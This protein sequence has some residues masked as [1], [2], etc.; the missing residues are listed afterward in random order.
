MFQDIADMSRDALIAMRA[1][2]EAVLASRE[3]GDH[4]TIRHISLSTWPWSQG[5]RAYDAEGA[6][7]PNLVEVDLIDL[8]GRQAISYSGVD[9]GE[10]TT[11]EVALSSVSIE[12]PKGWCKLARSG[13]FPSH[14]RLITDETPKENP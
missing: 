3:T 2:I 12:P 14:V 11:R 6:E 8:T 4:Q 7:I 10:P 13:I 5:L 9:G 1:R